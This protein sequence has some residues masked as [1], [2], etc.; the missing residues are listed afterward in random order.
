DR[1]PLSR[2]GRPGRVASADVVARDDLAVPR[3]TRARARRRAVD[4]RFLVLP[5]VGA[6]VRRTA[7]PD[8]VGS[9]LLGEHGARDCR[10]T[11]ALRRLVL[12]GAEARDQAVN[13]SAVVL[14]SG[15]LDSMVC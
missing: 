11:G 6:F 13:R 14:L 7:G 8:P 2:L 3:H 1:P 9:A 5:A 12:G 10:N 15:G 4:E